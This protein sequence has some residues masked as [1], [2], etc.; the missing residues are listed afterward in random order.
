VPLP[1]FSSTR[2]IFLTDEKP[3]FSRGSWVKQFLKEESIAEESCLKDP[4]A[5]A[6]WL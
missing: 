6:S 4:P 2:R 3:N 1:G 5:L